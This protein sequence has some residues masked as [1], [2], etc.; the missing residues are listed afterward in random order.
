MR[1]PTG[2]TT[3]DNENVYVVCNESNY[4]V[5]VSPDGKHY[6]EL[7]DCKRRQGYITT[8]QTIIC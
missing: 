8:N 5:V 3:D 6:K 2:V 4:V 1:M 7:L